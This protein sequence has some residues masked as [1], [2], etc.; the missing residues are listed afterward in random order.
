MASAAAAVETTSVGATSKARPP[1]GG[2]ASCIPAVI[3]AAERAGACSWLS[4]KRRMSTSV[5]SIAVVEIAMVKVAAIEVVAAEIVAI[6]YR[7]AVG[8]VGVGVVD[9]CPTVPVISPVMPAPSDSS[10]S[11]NSKSKPEG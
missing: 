11:A 7:P 5:V 9:H 8:D 1:A 4:V 6:D 2:K 10:E 3:K